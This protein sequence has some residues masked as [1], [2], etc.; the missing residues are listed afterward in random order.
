M[1]E[2]D[3]ALVSLSFIYGA[4][5]D[6]VQTNKQMKRC[7]LPVC[8]TAGKTAISGDR[9]RSRGRREQLFSVPERQPGTLDR[10]SRGL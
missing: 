5:E 7:N 10:H 9:R 1:D 2:S 3:T 8:L 4:K 6:H